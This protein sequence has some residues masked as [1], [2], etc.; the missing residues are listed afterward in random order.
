[1]SSRASLAPDFLARGKGWALVLCVLAVVG[2]PFGAQ[3]GVWGAPTA[4]PAAV[5]AQHP[6]VGVLVVE[7]QGTCTG[8]L[9][10]P[11]AVLTAA[12]CF[13]FRSGEGAGN[14]VRYDVEGGAYRVLYDVPVVSWS[15]AP[16]GFSTGVFANDWALVRLGAPVEGVR[17]APLAEAGPSI[18][19]GVVLYGG[20]RYGPREEDFDWLVREKPFSWGGDPGSTPGDSGGPIF[21]ARGELVAIVSGQGLFR[22]VS[23]HLWWRRE[24]IEARLR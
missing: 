1:M 5:T 11:D 14:F 6:E 22:L 24:G 12:H 4:P 10:R 20:G 9:V 8:V 16:W 7:G 21:N 18:G 23:T 13:G 15:A 2:L 3:A 17:P 19:E